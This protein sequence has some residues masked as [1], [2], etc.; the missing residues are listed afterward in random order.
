[1]TIN[2]I[3]IGFFTLYFLL[4]YLELCHLNGIYGAFITLVA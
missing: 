2:R 3:A 4:F 1:M